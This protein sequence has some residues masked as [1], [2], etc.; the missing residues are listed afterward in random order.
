[1]STRILEV[2]TVN[3]RI[4]LNEEL[5][6]KTRLAALQAL[7]HPPLILLLKLLAGSKTP[8]RLVALAAQRDP[9]E[10]LRRELRHKARRREK[11]KNAG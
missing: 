8:P 2:D 9:E 4:V 10:I 7:P 1:M 11:E 5:P 3:K 6:Q